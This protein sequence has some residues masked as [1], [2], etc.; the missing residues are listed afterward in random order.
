RELKHNIEFVKSLARKR[1]GKCLSENYIDT[2]QPLLWSCIESHKW[3]A[4]LHSIQRDE[5]DIP[6]YDLG[7]AIE[8]QEEQYN[9]YIKFFH[10]G[11]PN[12][13]AKQQERDQLKK[14]LCKEN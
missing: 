8:V 1:N 14:K 6:Y 2:N 10:K 11:D 12:I 3:N 4:S 9:K 13:F 5:F 7:F